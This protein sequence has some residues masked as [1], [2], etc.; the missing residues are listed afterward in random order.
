MEKAELTELPIAP[1]A[2]LGELQIAPERESAGEF[3]DA[4][5]EDANQYTLESEGDPFSTPLKYSGRL[6]F[7]KWN[8]KNAVCSGQF[9][10]PRVVLTAAHC[11]RDAETGRWNGNFRFALQY[12]EGRYRQQYATRCVTTKHGWVKKRRSDRVARQ[13][14]YAMLLV[15]EPSRTGYFGW[16][17]GWRGQYKAAVKI[18]YPS[19][20]SRGRVVQVERGPVFFPSKRPG[21]VAIRHNNRLSGK[22]SS[23]GAFVANYSRRGGSNT[24][25]VISVTSASY[26]RDPLT[27][28]GPY[29]DGGFKTMLAYVA[30]GCR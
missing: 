4:S 9:I 5:H 15:D 14:D 25:R 29:L 26:G 7:K 18:G 28:I 8:G 27:D 17:S 3:G 16:H 22:G 2:E 13:Y 11:V 30:R 20:I 12:H 6:F 24:N 1:P 21:L 10:A 19:E 23:G